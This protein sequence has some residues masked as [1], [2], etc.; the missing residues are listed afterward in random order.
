MI[1][2]SDLRSLISMC[3]TV[4]NMKSPKPEGIWKSLR[5]VII[6]LVANIL[7]VTNFY[8]YSM[9][10]N[11]QSMDL[12]LTTQSMESIP[13]RSSE[14]I[15]KM[16]RPTAIA[17]LL[18]YDLPDGYS[19]SIKSVDWPLSSQAI[20]SRVSA[21]SKDVDPNQINSTI[22]SYK[23]TKGVEYT[24]GKEGVDGTYVV[25]IFPNKRFG[26]IEDAQKILSVCPNG[27]QLSPKALSPSAILFTDTCGSDACEQ[28]RSTIEPTLAVE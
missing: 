13:V 22:D 15:A 1:R 4:L 5:I 3:Y 25:T 20:K 10:I 2:V 26:S 24:F 23:D 16:N 17:Q 7:L 8:I 6:L 18:G 9:Y 27:G 12:S 14:S 21:C 19:V 28:V 11:N